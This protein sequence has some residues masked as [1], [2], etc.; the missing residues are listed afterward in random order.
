MRLRPTF[1]RAPARAA[2]AVG[3]LLCASAYL[4]IAWR[5]P[6]LLDYDD[7]T[8]GIFTNDLSSGAGYDATFRGSHAFQ[9]LYR[10]NWAV[11]RLPYTLALAGVQ[12]LLGVPRHDV[13]RLL[14]AFA[15]LFAA[16]GSLLAA[17]ALAR[18]ACGS[19]AERWAI[20]AFVAVHPAFVPFVRTGASFYLLAFALFWA[21]IYLTLRYA[22]SGSA[23]PLQGLAVVLALF[24]LNPYPPLAALPLALPLVLLAH[25]RLRAALADRRVWLAAATSVLLFAGASAAAALFAEGSLRRYVEK[26]SAFQAARS[27]AV[28]LRQLAEW[29]PAE[30]LLGYVDQ[31]L[32]FR[33]DAL[34]DPSRDDWIWVPGRPSYALL[35]T[36]PVMA[37]GAVAGL[38]RRETS[39]RTCV[40]VLAALGALFASVSFPEGRYLL[41]AVPCY[42][43]LAIR[44][45]RS[46]LPGSRARELALGVALSLLALE[47]GSIVR[48]HEREV[49]ERW[50]SYD[51]I[52]EAAVRLARFGDEPILVRLPNS[53]AL[54]P[55]LYFRMVMPPSA[56]WVGADRFERRLAG[57]EPARLVAVEYAEREPQLARLR[58][59]GFAEAGAFTTRT[60]GRSMRILTRPPLQRAGRGEASIPAP[61]PGSGAGEAPRG[62]TPDR[63]R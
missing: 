41:A 6:T 5:G 8:Q 40:A 52:R 18:G 30:K 21:A 63:S 62:A 14:G 57:G 11:Q 33:V 50:R 56:R 16:L 28:S 19:G 35:A 29:S 2:L 1:P 25:G 51:G 53:R 45:A 32:L 46:L 59:L 3:V 20:G 36:L 23:R 43:L 13:E 54:E 24:A 44:G 38:R 7:A 42:G 22:E 26:I 31:H 60:T 12:L 37:L 49:L 47:T 10:S 27:H 48:S 55:S 4:P 17:L 61:S 9:D 34:G 58:A 15:A 39:T